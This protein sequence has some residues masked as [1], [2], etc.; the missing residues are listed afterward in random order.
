MTILLAE[1]IGTFLLILLGNGC[2]ANVLLGGSKGHNSGW[3]VITTGWGF[4]VV[5]AVYTVGWI[6]GAHLNPAVTLG[7]VIMNKTPVYLVPFY[8]VGQFIG[9]M[10]G[11]FCVWIS[12]LPHWKK[13]EDNTSKLLCFATKPIVRR[14]GWNFVIE[15]IATA[16]LLIGILGILERHNHL[17]VSLAPYMIGIVIWSIGLSLGGPTG[18]AI[19]PARD[20]GPR[21]VHQLLPIPG[22]SDWGYA[23]VPILGPLAGSALGSL[24]FR[25]VLSPMLPQVLH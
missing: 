8:L 1:M 13:T 7:F 19:N 9:A 24:F 21:I 2:V 17:G 3:I 20:L 23:W 16:V 12:Y 6:S 4:A 22:S 15:I 25:Y 5:I 11:A 10:I 14:L 18:F